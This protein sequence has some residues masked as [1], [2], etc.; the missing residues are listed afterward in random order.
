MKSIM[1]LSE[2]E[3]EKELTEYLEKKVK[4]TV[5]HSK[6]V[7]EICK[8]IVTYYD[9]DLEEEMKKLLYISAMFHD[10]SKFDDNKKR[11][12]KEAKKVLKSMFQK[13]KQLKKVCRIIACHKGKFNPK[14]DILIPAAI[15]RIAD[16]IDKI[17][18]DKIDDFVD[19]YSSS[20]EKI[21]E[22]FIKNGKDFEKFKEACDKVKIETEKIKI[23]R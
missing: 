14:D 3:C 23:L 8:K 10:I 7:L 22:S 6:R 4:K 2:N 12:H 13:G 11:H 9:D 21:K 5:A 19:K 17:N 15:L 18:K 16:K 20:M 1:E